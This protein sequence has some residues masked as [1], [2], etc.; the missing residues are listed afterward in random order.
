MHIKVV[1]AIFAVLFLSLVSGQDRIQRDC[2]ELER[3][4][5]ECVGT[6]NNREDR[7]LPTLNRECQQKTIR[8]WH[9]RDIGRCELTKIDCLGW[10]SRLDCGDIARLAGM[11]RRN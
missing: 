6:L 2:N 11:R 5:R 7:N 10:E 8:T 3:K 4:C 9:W 1:L